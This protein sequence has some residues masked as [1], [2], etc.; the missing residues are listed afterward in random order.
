MKALR[1][2][3]YQVAS[4][5]DGYIAGPNGEYDWIIMDP[6]ID[7]TGLFEQFDTLLMGRKTYQVIPQG[8]N[9]G[10]KVVV[11]SR[12]LQPEQ[13]PNVVI[14]ADRVKETIEEMKAQPGKDIWLF[15]GGELFRSLLDLGV[16]D[17]VEL[18]VIPVL[19]GGG[20]P[21][22]PQAAMQQKLSL[23]NHRVYSK[24]GIV[25]LEYDVLNVAV[26]AR[27]RAAREVAT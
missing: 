4:S 13:H 12:T 5:L 17:S 14:V 18:A 8:D 3:R 23:R 6:D 15:G 24:S 2:V 16:V 26:K 11:V 9:Q 27:K 19:L 10:Q 21:F 22:L 1:R 25:M 7:F 20:I